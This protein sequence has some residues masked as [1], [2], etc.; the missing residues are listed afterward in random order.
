MADSAAGH[1]KDCTRRLTQAACPYIQLPVGLDTSTAQGRMI[2]EDTVVPVVGGHL[3]T[4]AAIQD[5]G[6]LRLKACRMAD[7]APL[8]SQTEAELEKDILAPRARMDSRLAPDAEMAAVA[9]SRSP[10]GV[11]DMMA[12]TGTTGV[13]KGCGQLP[14]AYRVLARLTGG[15]PVS[16][17]GTV[18]MV[19]PNPS[20]PVPAPPLNWFNIP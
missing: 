11:Q 16:G 9:L 8:G 20:R 14:V 18:P 4:E 3:C 7:P 2:L 5:R 15:G 12:V 13:Q 6:N 10:E 19:A 1:T 17:I